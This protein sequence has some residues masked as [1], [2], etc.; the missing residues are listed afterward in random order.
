VEQY[1][2]LIA[3]VPGDD[4]EGL[5]PVRDLAAGEV[6]LHRHDYRAALAR[7]SAVIAGSTASEWWIRQRAAHAHLGA[8]QAERGLGHQRAAVA[9]LETAIRTLTGLAALNENVEHRQR[10]ARAN[11]ELAGVLGIGR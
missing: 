7:F 4:S 2:A 3:L 1:T 8:G 9:H 10:L 11:V 5:V 6:A